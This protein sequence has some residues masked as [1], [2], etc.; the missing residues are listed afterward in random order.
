M[1]IRVIICLGK[2]HVCFSEI[3]EVLIRKDI[4]R[5]TDNA[6]KKAINTRSAVHSGNIRNTKS[7]GGLMNVSLM[8]YC[9]II[10]LEMKHAKQF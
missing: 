10:E 5:R 3:F 4:L 7:S 2:E 9:F 6:D 1:L 8:F